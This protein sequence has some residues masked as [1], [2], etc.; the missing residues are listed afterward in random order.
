MVAA[1][2]AVLYPQSL[3]LFVATYAYSAS[4]L[5]VPL[6]A[7]M[8]LITRGQIRVMDS[9]VSIAAG[10]IGCGIAHVIG[11]TIPYTTFGILASLVVFIIAYLAVKPRIKPITPASEPVENKREDIENLRVKSNLNN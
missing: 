7:V 1:L 11:I 6:I 10:L 9:Y 5:A 3:D 8:I 2:L 4:V